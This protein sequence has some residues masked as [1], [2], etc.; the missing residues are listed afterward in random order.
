MRGMVRGLG[1]GR[2][3]GRVRAG[4]GDGR[5]MV[6]RWQGWA[7]TAQGGLKHRLGGWQGDGEGMLGGQ[8]VRQ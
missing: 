6:G 3:D 4:S 5:E 2:L 1:D 8:W 7:E